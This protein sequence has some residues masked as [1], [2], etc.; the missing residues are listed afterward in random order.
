MLQKHQTD[1]TAV[2]DTLHLHTEIPPQIWYMKTIPSAIMA[3][4][5][6]FGAAFIEIYFVLSSLFG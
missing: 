6:P 5:L 4:V 1:W 3:G 2:R